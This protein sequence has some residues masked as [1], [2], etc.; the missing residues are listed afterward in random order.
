MSDAARQVREFWFGRQPS[1]GA[2]LEQRLRLWFGAAEPA[3]RRA[4]D[5]EIARRFS[6]LVR[7]AAA[8]ELA[9]WA[10]SPRRR[11]ALIL[12]L[13]Q[14]PRHIHRGSAEAFATDP[15]A[16]ALSLSGIQSGADAA[17]EPLERL[18]FYMPLQ[19][20]EMREVQEESVAAYRRLL[21]ESPQALTAALTAALRAAEQHRALIERFGRFPQRNAVLG[22]TSSPQE[23]SF[24]AAA[25][26]RFS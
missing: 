19:H 26:E 9:S 14:F 1:T 15:Q 4:I 24:L 10:A 13:D 3:L 5:A 21:Q 16:L 7:Q 25:G 12:L 8:G 6:T 20:A 23:E 18:F 22:R 2:A 11:L 17:L